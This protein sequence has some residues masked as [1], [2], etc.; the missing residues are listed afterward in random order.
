MTADRSAEYLASLVRELC[1]LP[2]E[3]EWVE[4]KVNNA[5]LQDIGEYLSALANAAALHGKACAYLLWGIEDTTHRIVGT[6]FSPSTVRKGNEALENWLLRLL[7]PQVEIRFT[8]LNVDG[9]P[10]V[11]LEIAAAANRPVRFAGTEYIR[12]GSYKKPLK[13]FPEK[14]RALWR[15]FDHVPFEVGVA[16]AHASG[17]EVLRLLDYPAYFDLLQ[18]PPP[19]GHA[20]IL[21][22]LRRDNLIAANAAGAW[23][24]THLGALALARDLRAFGRLARKALRVVVYRGVGRVET[25]REFDEPRG[26]A[27]AFDALIQKIMALLPAAEVIESGLRRSLTAYPEIAVRELV[28]NA[29]IHQDFSVTGA[30]PTVEIFEGRIEITNPG[31]PLVDTDRFLD[32]PPLSRNEGLASLLRRF[33]ICEERGSGI[34]KVVAATESAQLPPPRFERPP[35]FTRATLWAARPLAAMDKEER[36]RACYLHAGLMYLQGAFLTNASVRERFGIA[37]PNRATASRLIR[38]ALGSGLIVPR[39]REAA[40]S[41]MKYLPWWA[42]EVRA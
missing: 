32:S 5:D 25:E 13:D 30:G 38:D 26:Y 19:D 18:Q 9:Q 41:Q 16:V 37:F 15:G 21:D 2:H 42:V 35:G 34:D 33:H 39:D 28:A 6:S 14:E 23:E 4:F 22:A 20:A 3:T 10:I 40:P 1:K 17:D 7:E 24:I 36:A 11:L 31:E 12:V 8:S 29:L 27:S